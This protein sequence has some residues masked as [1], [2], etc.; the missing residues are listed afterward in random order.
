MFLDNVTERHIFHLQTSQD[1]KKFGIGSK[2][3]ATLHFSTAKNGTV[4]SH[5]NR[6]RAKQ[7]Q[8]CPQMNNLGS[9]QWA[10][11]ATALKLTTENISFVHIS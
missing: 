3:L 7:I 2:T 1:K 11:K 6:L 10:M 8:L 5:L 4:D 9:E